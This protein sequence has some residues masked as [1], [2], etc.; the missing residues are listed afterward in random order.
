MNQLNPN[1]LSEGE[2][3]IIEPTGVSD[4][5][6]QS[7][8][9]QSDTRNQSLS[10]T[11]KQAATEKNTD[12]AELNQLF[13]ELEE[14]ITIKKKQ[15]QEQLDASAH[16]YADRQKEITAKRENITLNVPNEFDQ[17]EALEDDD[18]FLVEM[19]EFIQL[20]SRARLI[21][22]LRTCMPNDSA[23][24]YTTINE[25][26]NYYK[27][28]LA[29]QLADT[30]TQS[31]VAHSPTMYLASG[32]D[33]ELPLLLQSRHIIM[34]DPCFSQLKS[35]NYVINKVNQ[36][37]SCDPE[38]KQISPFHH[39]IKFRFNFGRDLETVNLDLFGKRYQEYQNFLPLGCILEYNS[40]LDHS[41]AK[42]DLIA[43]LMTGGLIINNQPSPM[44]EVHVGWL[45]RLSN[46]V[47]PNQIEDQNAQHLGLT[48]L[49]F[50]YIPFAVY[51]KHASNQRLLTYSESLPSVHQ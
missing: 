21:N 11:A 8:Q 41:L 19:D 4:Q 12:L 38:I 36:Y 33:I 29:M 20:P 7:H 31:G 44:R 26:G 5:S 40:A 51:Q 28:K 39:H 1:F 47:D 16:K 34:V 30:I 37:D 10:T 46:T 25:Y 2:E 48:A 24:E 18:D 23:P 43:K 35:V 45:N 42:S 6:N 9:A 50:P 49:R 22:Q 14:M 13:D 15:Q 3:I 32:I 27:V 17:I